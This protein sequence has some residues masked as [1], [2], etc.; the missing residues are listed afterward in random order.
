MS[1][2][3]AWAEAAADVASSASAVLICSRGALRLVALTEERQRG[4][5]KRKGQSIAEFERG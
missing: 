1:S 3:S 5:R 2:P 4:G